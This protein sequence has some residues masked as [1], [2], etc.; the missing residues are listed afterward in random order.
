MPDVESD[1][2]VLW[3]AVGPDGLEVICPGCLT[4]EEETAMAE[5]T[6]FVG[7]EADAVAERENGM[8]AVC[9][10]ARVD[11]GGQCANGCDDDAP[12]RVLRD[13]YDRLDNA[14]ALLVLREASTPSGA[15]ERKARLAGFREGVELAM[16][17][18]REGM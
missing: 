17:Y 13:L 16:T 6:M 2:A 8:C 4:R 1:E 9:G 11:S 12:P 7:F 15:F 5:D 14:R 3:E 10:S 18:V